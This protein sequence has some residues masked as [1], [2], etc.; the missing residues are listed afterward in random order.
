MTEKLLKT[1]IKKPRVFSDEEIRLKS[2]RWKTNNPNDDPIARAKKIDKQSKVYE[3]TDPDGSVIVVKN[4]N[5]FCKDNGLSQ[6]N[7]TAVAQGK[8]KQANGWKCKFKD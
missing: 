1:T 7:M 4:L 3:I 6:G 2:E 5:Q 8:F